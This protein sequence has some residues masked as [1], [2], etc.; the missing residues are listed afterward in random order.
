MTSSYDEAG[1]YIYPDGFDPETGEWQEGFDEARARWEKQYAEAHERWEAHKKQIVDAEKAGVEAADAG[2]YSA[3]AE[4]QTDDEG[5]SLASDEALQALRE[6]LTGRRRVADRAAEQRPPV[7]WTGGL[8]VVDPTR[9]L[10]R[11]RVQ[12]AA[13]RRAGAVPSSGRPG[14]RSRQQEPG[15]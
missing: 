4:E 11:E 3:G 1:N 13:G 14:G 8:V 9:P 5:G 12:M 15:G 6:K 7:L 10:W 2:S